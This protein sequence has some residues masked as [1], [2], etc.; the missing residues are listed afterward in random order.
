MSL[1]N[2]KKTFHKKKVIVTGHTGFKGSWLTLWLNKLGANVLGLSLNVPTKPSIYECINIKKKINNKK[3]DIRNLKKLRAE[4]NKFKPDFI[5]HLAAQSLVKKSLEDPVKTWETNTI[6]TI[7][8]LESVKTMKNDCTLILITSDKCYKN[9]ETNRGYKENDILG[10]K[11]PYSASKASAELAIESYIKSFYIG[12]NKNIK[13]GI[14]RAGN[15]IGGGD[16]SRNRLIPDCMR[17]IE[18]GLRLKLRSPFS[19]RPWQHVLEAISGYLYLAS[20]LNRN[21]KLNY[22]AFNFGPNKKNNHTVLDLIK[23]M[24]KNWNK[25]KWI[26]LKKNQF[27]ESNLLRLNISKANKKLKWKPILSFSETSR[28]VVTWYM[29]YYNN[30]NMYNFSL[31][32]INQYEKKMTKKY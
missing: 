12:K 25:I 17:S 13:I 8:I 16:W 20:S 30:K 5:F 18:K 28:M 14:A 26:V 22:E 1:I 32:Q 23:S 27:D 7:N 11:D 21:K 24:K 10:G 9:R 31:E 6:G 15:V 4:I 3:V 29:S 2:L 19:T